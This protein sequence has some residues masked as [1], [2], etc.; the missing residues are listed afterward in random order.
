VPA[1]TKSLNDDS[2]HVLL[3]LEVEDSGPG[4][5]EDQLDTIFNS[6][7]QGNH[8]GDELEETG[9]GLA[10]CRS[11][12]NMMEGRINVT[13]KPGQGTSFTVT[14]PVALAE[15]SAFARETG[16]DVQV[17]TLKPGQSPKRILVVDDNADNRTL[18]SSMLKHSGSKCVKL[19]M[20]KPLSMNSA[21]GGPT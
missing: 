9:L 21:N 10:I 8:H 3:E 15:A 19:V 12:V 20:A 14:L 6:F 18:L 5:P 7:V 4:I 2:D 11:L 17:L 13:S 16:Q 1:C